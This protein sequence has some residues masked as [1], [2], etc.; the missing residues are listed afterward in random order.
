MNLPLKIAR[1]YLFAKKSTNA[2]NI[3]SGISVFGISVGTAALILVLSV[4]NGFE[5]L[6]SGLFSSFNPDIK[7]LPADSKIFRPEE[8]DIQKLKEID[9]VLFVSSTLEEV[10]FFEYK[11]SQDFGILKGVD[12]Y[13]DEV[14]GIDSTLREGRYVLDQNDRSMAVM[15]VVMRNNLSVN[16]EDEFA[17]LN[18]YMAKR[19][20][21]AFGQPFK[22]RILYPA[23]TFVI[24]QDFESRYVLASL[25]FVREILGYPNELTA[26][27][28]KL[29]PE[30][31]IE[32]VKAEIATIFN[33][34]VII[35]DRYQ[36]DEAF[37]KLMNIEK[38][39]SYAILSLTLI[40]VAFNM[41]GA[42]WM[43]VMDKQKDIAILKSMGAVDRTIRNVFLNEGLLLSLMGLIIG[44]TIAIV[45]YASQKMF[46]LV[47]IP[48]GFVVEAYPISIRLF[49][50]IVVALTVITIGFLA[51]IPP[52]LRAAR[53]SALIRED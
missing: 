2:I 48:S 6:I 47:P 25:G 34:E 16:I 50:F 49:D 21:T 23:G 30:A 18:V 27:E 29:S 11:G 17:S 32:K 36:Q 51:S 20:K 19:K 41:I 4:F 35:K 8:T 43:I 9:G 1:R 7:V 45:L 13:F 40:L 5:E 28:L 22:K 39:L 42:L 26:L 53:V 24:Q 37:L 38:W 15:G 52:A 33:N 10:A 46:G 31:D 12:Q 3:I 44:F 14:T